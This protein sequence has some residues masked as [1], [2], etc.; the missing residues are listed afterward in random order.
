MP[1]QP[2]RSVLSVLNQTHMSL[3]NGARASKVDSESV[4]Y[5]RIVGIVQIESNCV[6]SKPNVVIRCKW[7]FRRGNSSPARVLRGSVRSHYHLHRSEIQVRVF[8]VFRLS[9]PEVRNLSQKQLDKTPIFEQNARWV[10][11]LQS[12]C[13]TA[14]WGTNP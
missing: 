1:N 14:R 12:S 2:P 11:R 9:H 8:F 10:V 13:K 3:K 5:G 4:L 6:H 7:S